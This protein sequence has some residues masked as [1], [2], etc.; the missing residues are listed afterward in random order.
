MR[1]NKNI[2][3]GIKSGVQPT[4]EKRVEFSLKCLKQDKKKHCP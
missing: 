2:K 3:K 4:I 1:T